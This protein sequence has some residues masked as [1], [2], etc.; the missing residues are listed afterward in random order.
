[1]TRSSDTGRN[2]PCP[3]GSG[4]KF[5]H[6]CLGRAESLAPAGPASDAIQ[7]FRHAMEGR[8]F[9]STEEVQAFVRDLNEQRNRRP[10]DDF[11]GLSP[12]QMHRFLHFPFDSPELVTFPSRLDAPPTA[13]IMTAFGLLAEAIGEDGLK[14]TA[15]GNLPLKLVRE[16]AAAIMGAENCAEHPPLGSIRTETD[17]YDLHVTRLVAQ[18]S[19]LIRKYRGKF[20]LTRDYRALLKNHGMEGIYPRLLRAYAE[21]FNWDYRDRYPELWFIQQSFLFTLYL[22][23]RYGGEWRLSAFYE[24]AFLSAFPR[25]VEEVEPT[26]YSTP[27]DTVRRCYS[28]RCLHNFAGFLGLVE[29]KWESRG[30]F[31]RRFRL[32]RAPLLDE[33]VRFQD[34]I[35]V[36]D[37]PN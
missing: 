3:C 18:L 4:K 27:E 6:C 2:D 25:I 35:K 29:P 20:L 30:M 21:R 11:A 37:H 14:A 16:A 23:H 34:R 24:D 12:E 19:G 28:W 10:I 22:L 8:E 31:E 33:A 32:R 5:K 13:P 7:E 15:K 36:P 26:S 17:F 1:M 9:A